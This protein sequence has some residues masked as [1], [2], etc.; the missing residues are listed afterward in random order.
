MSQTISNLRRVRAGMAAVFA[1]WAGVSI[2]VGG[3]WFF[4][5]RPGD[6]SNPRTF[7]DAVFMQ[8]AVWGVING[9]FAVG[10]I[11]QA[12][13]AARTPIE[14]AGPE[15]DDA[16]KLLAYLKFNTKLNWLWLLTGVGLL[17]AWAFTRN[18]GLAGHGVGVAIQAAFL[19][20]FDAILTRRLR[21]VVG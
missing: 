10:G 11:R 13:A 7:F 9:F 5:V 16:K 20:V 15:I 21:A 6:E 1:G 2:L 12:L 14:N 18:V 4:F 17:V 8:F 19:F 3:L